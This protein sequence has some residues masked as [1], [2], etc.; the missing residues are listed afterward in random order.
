MEK[1]LIFKFPGEYIREYAYVFFLVPTLYII[2]REIRYR[3]YKLMQLKNMV[4]GVAGVP[5]WV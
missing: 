1:I 2:V 5:Q 4:P 3:L